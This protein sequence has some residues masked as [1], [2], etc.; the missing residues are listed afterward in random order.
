MAAAVDAEVVG[1]AA[2]G[3]RLLGWEVDE[4]VFFVADTFIGP[5]GSDD[6]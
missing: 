5:D 6:A 4:D 3:T 1:T 2:E